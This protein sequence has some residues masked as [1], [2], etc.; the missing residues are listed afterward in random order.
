MLK[1]VVVA[2]GV[3]AVLFNQILLIYDYIIGAGR[4]RLPC[5]QI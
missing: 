5:S 3:V 1:C 4:M 2:S